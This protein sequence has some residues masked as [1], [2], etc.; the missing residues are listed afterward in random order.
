[1]QRGIPHMKATPH[2]ARL[3][4]LLGLWVSF[5]ALS[6]AGS[7]L[8]PRDKELAQNSQAL[9][10]KVALN[11]ELR[12]SQSPLPSA[13]KAMIAD[14]NQMQLA[15]YEDNVLL[16]TFPIL[17]RGREGTFWETPTGR[18]AI[19]TK[20]L[21][22]FSSIGG[23][24]MPY[25]MQ[26][27]GNFFI[28]GW[29]TYPDGTEVAKGYSGGCIRLSTPDAR[30][31]YE[32][33]DMGMRIVVTG[34]EDRTHFATSS[35]YYLRGDGALPEIAAPMFIVADTD[36]G[37]VLW[38][39]RAHEFARPQG[40]TLLMTALTALE[41]V[42]QYKIV[43]MGELLLGEAVLRK[44]SIGAADE[45]PAGTLLYP[46]LFD[47]NDTAARVFARD[48]GTKRFVAYMNEKAAAIGMND[49]RFGGAMSTDDSTT[50]PRD[51]LTLLSYIDRSKH[52]LLD[53]SLTPVRTLYDEEGKE[54]YV[55]TNKNPWL[56]EDDG[57]YQGGFAAI[58][59][60]G[61]SGSA[62]LL[63]SLPLSEFGNK[64]ISF[65]VLDSPNIRSDVAF[66]RKFVEE[67]FVYG[68]ERETEFTREHNEPTPSLLQKAK[69]L[70]NLEQLLQEHIVYEREV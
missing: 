14:L 9:L 54:R 30:E 49:T 69:G 13:G 20:E 24:W 66:L 27:Y 44:S 23:T 6:M 47:G 55:W 5:I 4:L 16:K 10:Y 31:V 39:R 33:A 51:L 35:R 3:Y 45:I 26:F 64:R 65:V 18:Y 22:H 28:H 21:K 56:Q 68:V 57:A 37:K 8:L 38:E 11:Q 36:A 61:V 29:P 17:S 43:R 15:L 52:F 63:L 2:H 32:F 60:D 53:I 25:S 19:Q 62:I 58:N 70:I 59:N 7:I 34:A 1:M 12:R 67:H 40:L 41:T 48:H 50:T 42:N 46:M